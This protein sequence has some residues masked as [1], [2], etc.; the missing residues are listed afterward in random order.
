MRLYRIKRRFRKK[1][2]NERIL[3]IN[4]STLIVKERALFS[5]SE[6][7]NTTKGVLILTG[8]RIIFDGKE[9]LL[10]DIKST[11]A[12]TEKYSTGK[13]LCITISTKF[14]QE[15]MFLMEYNSNWIRQECLQ[16]KLSV[17]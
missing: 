12:N 5:K 4:Y 13:I 16:L 2:P 11:M 8:R 10:S 6:F 7:Q 1:S 3:A 15:V 9:I 17:D 14:N